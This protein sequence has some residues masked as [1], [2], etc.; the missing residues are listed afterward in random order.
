MRAKRAMKR[1]WPWTT[2]QSNWYCV[3]RSPHVVSVTVA[4]PA[5]FRSEGIGWFDDSGNFNALGS[6]ATAATTSPVGNDPNLGFTGIQLASTVDVPLPG[7]P[8]IGGLL[9][10]LL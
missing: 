9:E 10:G 6:V 4:T 8:P 5:G 1:L 2:K 3:P 7:S